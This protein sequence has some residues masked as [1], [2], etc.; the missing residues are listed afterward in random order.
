MGVSM[1][2]KSVM[3]EIDI[4]IDTYCCGCFLKTGLVKDKGKAAAHLFCISGCT[5]GEHLKFLG[6]QLSRIKK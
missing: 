4:S 6:D 2:K 5:V 3:D 1:D